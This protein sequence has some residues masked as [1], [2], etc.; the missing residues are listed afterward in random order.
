MTLRMAGRASVAY[1]Y[2]DFRD[3]DK[4]RRRDLLPSLLIQLSAHSD[5]CCDTLARLYAAHGRGVHKPSDRAMTD[6]LKE[7]LA[8]QGQ[9]PTYIIMD[10][11]DEC[12]N[13]S[14]IP[15]SREEVLEL[16][17]ELVD[18]CLPNLHICVTSRPEID[19]KGVLQPLCSHPV[20]LHDETGQM[21]DI[22][23][24]VSHVVQSDDTMRRWRQ[25]DKDRV[26]KT[27]SEKADGM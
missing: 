4:Q 3:I 1:F 9:G 2:F 27:L 11:L 12:P 13:I 19:I 17:R 8:V 7:M 5:T 24:Y 20:S 6:C 18:L 22:I 26:I 10:A 15:S 14:G 21:Q 16:L 23:N 25:E